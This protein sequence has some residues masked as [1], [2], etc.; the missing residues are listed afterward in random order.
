MSLR[1]IVAGPLSTVQD[2]GRFGHRALGVPTSGPFD[3]ASAAIANSL[4]RNPRG[5]PVVEMTGFGGIY[6][7][8]RPIAIALAGAP[9]QARVERVDGPSREILRR[10]PRASGPATVWSIGATPTGYRSYLA[11]LGGWRVPEVLGSRSDE[12][13]LSAGEDLP[14]DPGEVPSRRTDLGRIDADD[15]APIRFLDG[16]DAA[17]IESDSL[18]RPVFSVGRQSDRMGLR[19]EGVPLSV[20]ADPARLSSPVAPGSIQMAGGLPIVLGP[21]AGRW[22]DIRTSGR[23]SRPIS[24]GSARPAREIVSASS[25]SIWRRQDGPI[26]VTARTWP[27][28]RRCSPCSAFGTSRPFPGFVDEA[29]PPS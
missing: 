3:R 5:A 25:G 2:A 12:R 20:V 6:E 22:A 9:M 24:T 1:V 8:Q 14:A 18:V 7:A 17:S 15:P 29:A 16:P 21:R 10:R 19:L 27:G 26:A 4:L 28:S 23:S 11:V 13:P